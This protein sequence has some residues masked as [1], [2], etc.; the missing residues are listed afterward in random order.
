MTASKML[1]KMVKMGIFVIYVTL[2]FLEKSW[3]RCFIFLGLINDI[4]FRSFLKGSWKFLNFIKELQHLQ[5]IFQWNHRCK[6]SNTS[7]N[8]CETSFD[9]KVNASLERRSLI[10]FFSPFSVSNCN[11]RQNDP[12]LFLSFFLQLSNSNLH[13]PHVVIPISISF[14]KKYTISCAS[15]CAFKNCVLQVLFS[16]SS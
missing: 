13:R 16:S 9:V 4:N 5:F 14:V 3:V 10:S 1:L 7:D 11:A 12:C 6:E 15:L 2:M 8:F